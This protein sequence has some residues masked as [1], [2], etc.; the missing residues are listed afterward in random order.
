MIL[1]YLTDK[2]S[3][4]KILK[5][6]LSPQ[7]PEVRLFTADR[8]ESQVQLMKYSDI[9]IWALLLHKTTILKVSVK[10]SDLY[11]TNYRTY[12]SYAVNKP[13]P[14]EDVEYFGEHRFILTS[15]LEKCLEQILLLYCYTIRKAICAKQSAD[16]EQLEKSL[17]TLGSY[18]TIAIPYKDIYGQKLIREIFKKLS[19]DSNYTILD[20]K[21]GTKKKMY[22]HLLELED[23][24]AE[25]FH[26][27]VTDQFYGCLDLCTSDWD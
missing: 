20:R 5:E 16:S 26:T 17:N 13:V 3:V 25:R 8:E 7:V 27:Y 9:G 14:A 1:Y 19:D 15:Q 2:E 24:R 6:G 23:K 21:I 4:E 10:Q 18:A 12:A 11:E 22:M